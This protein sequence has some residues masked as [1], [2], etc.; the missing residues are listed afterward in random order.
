[1]NKAERQRKIERYGSEYFK[2]IDQYGRDAAKYLTFDEPVIVELGGKAY[3][4]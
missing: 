3:S 1:M 2:L 4:F